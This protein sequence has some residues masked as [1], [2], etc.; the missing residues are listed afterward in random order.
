MKVR[1]WNECCP[2]CGMDYWEARAELNDG[3]TLIKCLDCNEEFL[4]KYVRVLVE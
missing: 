1:I 4:I 3:M 2:N